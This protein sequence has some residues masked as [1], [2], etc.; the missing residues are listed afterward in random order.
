M[1]LLLDAGNTRIKWAWLDPAGGMRTGASYQHAGRE[2]ADL[3]EPVAQGDEPSPAAVYVSNVGGRTLGTALDAALARL[4]PAVPV[5]WLTAAAEGYGVRCA[6]AR[7]AQL[8]ADRWA[9]LIGARSLWSGAVAVLDFG[10]AITLDGLDAGGRHTGGLIA[11]GY[12]LMI[13]ALMRDTGDLAAAGPA[14]ADTGV[15][16]FATGTAAGIEAG[17]QHCIRGLL[18]QVTEAL[19]AWAPAGYTLAVTG[20]GLDHVREALPA[21]ARIEP[22]L[23]LHG[24]A[25]IAGEDS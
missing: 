1:K 3:L 4:W 10:T 13:R 16:L 19:D 6:Y 5:H 12:T 7:P 22:D 8:G 20:G 14:A 21:D 9:A 25:R 23:V 2:A 18:R 24:L 11:P 17:V 15:S